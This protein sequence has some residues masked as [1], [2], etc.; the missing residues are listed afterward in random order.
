MIPFPAFSQSYLPVTNSPGTVVVVGGGL[1]GMTAALRLKQAGHQVTVIE[2]EGRPGGRNLTLR[3]CFSEGLHVEAGAAFLL[4]NHT[5]VMGFIEELGLADQLRV[6][7]HNGEDMLYTQEIHQPVPLNDQPLDP[8][9]LGLSEKEMGTSPGQ[10]VVE[11]L[12]DAA[13]SVENYGDPRAPGWPPPELSLYDDASLAELLRRG[14]ALGRNAPAMGVS[15]AAYALV[16]RGYFDLM[17]EGPSSVSSLEQVRDLIVNQILVPNLIPIEPPNGRESPNRVLHGAHP[18]LRGLA[19]SGAAESAIA[20]PETPAP[21]TVVDPESPRPTA[22]DSG[23]H[24]PKNCCLIGGNDQ[25]AQAF[26]DLL[27]QDLVLNARVAEIDNRDSGV[28]VTAS[29]PNGPLLVEADRVICALPVQALN[30]IRFSVPLPSSKK[31][32][33]DKYRPT[34]VLRVF[35]EFGHRFWEEQDLSGIASTDLPEV[36]GQSRRIPGIWINNQT[37]ALPGPAGILECYIVGEWAELLNTYDDAALHALMLDQIERVYP[38]AAASWTGNAARKFWAS[39]YAWFAPG[40][41]G[42]ALRD[43][44]CPA[45]R[46][47]FAG[48]QYSA[49]PGWIQGAMESAIRA[50]REVNEAFL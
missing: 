23:S 50:A 1:A 21:L 35:F 15:E 39:A 18:A 10:W 32:A 44:P 25:L 16:S 2:A 41:L 34:R 33:F 24:P 49:I 13:A 43:G 47:H 12:D 45:G 46:V 14:G 19:T 9:P 26:A 20:R 30:Q 37:R 3:G 5:F 11:A 17:G 40:D 36:P 29:T 7:P 6:M 4:T 28:T 31:S 42:S 38:G 48:D 27:G 8:P 22:I